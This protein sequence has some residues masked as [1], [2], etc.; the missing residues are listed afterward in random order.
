LKPFFELLRDKSGRARTS[1]LP[2]AAVSAKA[3]PTAR[4]GYLANL[5]EGI[6]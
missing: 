3:R 2:L 5:I 1:E 6:S 4:C